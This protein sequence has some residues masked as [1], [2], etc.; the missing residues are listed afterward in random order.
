MPRGLVQ[1]NLV[2]ELHGTFSWGSVGV[3]SAFISPSTIIEM[4]F[5]I[6]RLIHVMC[7]H[8]IVWC[9]DWMPH[10]QIPKLRLV[11]GSTP[12]VGSL[13]KTIFGSWMI[14]LRRQ[15]FASIL[16]EVTLRASYFHLS[17]QVDRSGGHFSPWFPCRWSPLKLHRKKP[18]FSITSKSS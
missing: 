18:I 6:F 16:G 8:E 5:A 9:R 11:T 4:R 17:V 3:S 14:A 1:E 7:S 10:N 12:P 2:H 15:V 13:R